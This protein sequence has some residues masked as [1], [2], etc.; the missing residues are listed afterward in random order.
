MLEK[1]EG[2]V[3]EALPGLR[4]RVMLE[5]SQQEILAYAA[6]KMKLHRIRVL[7]GDRVVV[8][9]SPDGEKGRII[10]RL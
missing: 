6:G 3:T 2:V 5:K 7:Q 9:V 10:Q 4:F 1:Q 8:M